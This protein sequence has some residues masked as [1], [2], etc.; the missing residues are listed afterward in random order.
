MGDVI[1]INANKPHLAGKAICL[2]CKHEWAQVAPHGTLGFECPECA[3]AKG[4]FQG[5]VTPDSV[6]KCECGNHVHAL[7]PEGA[8]CLMCGEMQYSWFVT[9]KEPPEVTDEDL[10]PKSQSPLSLVKKTIEDL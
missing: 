7:T 10:P 2:Q 8:Q 1:D 3:C 9:I 6:W 4:V 5:L